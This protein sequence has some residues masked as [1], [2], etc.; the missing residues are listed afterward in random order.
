MVQSLLSEGDIA[1]TEDYLNEYLD[2]VNQYAVMNLCSNLI[3]NMVV[4]HY[5]TLAKENQVNFTL[6]INVPKELPIQDS[7]L[8]VLLGNLLENAITAVSSA[9]ENQCKIDL[10]IITAGK[11]LVVTV[12][13]GFGGK[14]SYENGEYRSTKPNHK[15]FGLKS[16]MAIAEKYNGHAEFTHE[17]MV[18]H[19]SV[20]LTFI[21][22]YL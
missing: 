7:D 2:T 17:D 12:D 15:A 5:Y 16:I 14:L 3:V 8:S 6:H 18:F 9:P 4:S 20:M 22:P 19:S 13:N 11:T 1:K 10:N 21:S